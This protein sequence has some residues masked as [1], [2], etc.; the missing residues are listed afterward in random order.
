MGVVLDGIGLAVPEAFV[1]ARGVLLNAGVEADQGGQT[2]GQT[3]GDFPGLFLIV[4]QGGQHAGRPFADGVQ[5]D[6]QQLMTV[7]GILKA[8]HDRVGKSLHFVLG[9]RHVGHD[10][11]IQGMLQEG[12][13]VLVRHAFAHGVQARQIRA[14]Y[15]GGVRAV[16]HADFAQLIRLYVVCEDNGVHLIQGQLLLHLFGAFDDPQ[17]EGFG[18]VQLLILIAQLLEHAG[19]FLAGEAG[20]DAVHQR[21]AEDVVVLEPADEI[22]PQ[23]PLLG[24]FQHG[25]LESSISS[26]GMMMKP[27]LPSRNRS[28]RKRVSLPG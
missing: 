27:G 22:V 14:K 9:Q 6:G 16:E 2:K 21:G 25:V 28:C 5:G 12:A 13:H 1:I 26:Q 23:L 4:L 17:A 18:G 10:F 8:Q 19:H 7:E 20:H 15:H 3:G 24:G 11:I